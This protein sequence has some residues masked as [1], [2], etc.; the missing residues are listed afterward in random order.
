MISMG[1]GRNGRV[2]VTNMSMTIKSKE[3]WASFVR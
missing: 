2:D 1:E 3:E